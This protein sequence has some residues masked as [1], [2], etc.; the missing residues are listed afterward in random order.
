MAASLNLKRARATTQRKRRW[1]RGAT[2]REP[3][4]EGEVGRWRFFFF[5]RGGGAA[6]YWTRIGGDVAEP[7]PREGNF[8]RRGRLSKFRVTWPGEDATV[9]HI[10]VIVN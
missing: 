8:G 4:G 5:A 3:R 9:Q 1:R 10:I 6:Y 7:C 2:V